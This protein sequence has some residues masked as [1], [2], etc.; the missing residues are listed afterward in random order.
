LKV[1]PGEVASIMRRTWVMESAALPDAG[2]RKAGKPVTL[3]MC[4]RIDSGRSKCRSHVSKGAKS[5]GKLH[6]KPR[7]SSESQESE[8]LLPSV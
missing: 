7:K 6:G 4:E 1:A 3:L 5:L 8:W 2:K